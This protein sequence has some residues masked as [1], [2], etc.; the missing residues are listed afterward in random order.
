LKQNNFCHKLKI[1]QA[2]ITSVG[3]STIPA[4]DDSQCR[5]QLLPSDFLLYGRETEIKR[6]KSSIWFEIIEK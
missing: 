5:W 1:S 2:S 3:Q 4:G 6:V